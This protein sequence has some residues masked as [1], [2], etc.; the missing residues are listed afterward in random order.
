MIAGPN[1]WDPN[2]RRAVVLVGHHDDEGALGVVLNRA[3]EVSVREAAPPFAA[4]V[5][6]D[7]VVFVG[8][9]VQPQAAV[10]IA[11][12]N[13][14]RKSDLAVANSGSGNLS[15]LLGRGDGTFRA[16]NNFPSGP[17][18]FSVASG[19]PGNHCQ[20][21]SVLVWKRTKKRTR[22]LVSFLT[23]RMR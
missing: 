12:F 16:P 15:V 9:P 20:P 11:D 23:L 21:S 7:G 3:S 10:V 18:P 13:N 1:L 2:F 6:D 8:G 4:L 22:T 5:G 19:V 17:Y 14:D